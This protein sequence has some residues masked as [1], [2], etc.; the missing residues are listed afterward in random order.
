MMNGYKKDNYWVYNNELESNDTFRFRHFMN[1]DIFI[2][3]SH[4]NITIPTYSYIKLGHS[5]G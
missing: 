4:H 5:F 1:S 2:Y 3:F